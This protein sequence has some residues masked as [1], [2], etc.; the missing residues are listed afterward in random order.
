MAE[1][2]HISRNRPVP[3]NSTTPHKKVQIELRRVMHCNNTRTQTSWQH[4]TPHKATFENCS[5]TKSKGWTQLLQHNT[6]LTNTADNP[7]KLK[8]KT[9]IPDAPCRPSQLRW[10]ISTCP[11]PTPHASHWTLRFS[12]PS[13][14]A[15]KLHAH[16][17][18]SH[19]LN[20]PNLVSNFLNRLS[21]T[22]SLSPA[23]NFPAHNF[24][25]D[26][27]KIKTARTQ[28]HRH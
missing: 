19:T 28:A 22:P 1:N 14:Y 16:T 9:P 13:S 17:Q 12:T 2:W 7:K 24:S 20:S 10:L 11:L 3:Q 15:I 26:F 23:Q 5:T 27:S 6:Q 25:L 18:L 21:P 8:P 4:S